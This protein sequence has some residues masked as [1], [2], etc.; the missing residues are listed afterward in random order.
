MVPI[1]TSGNYLIG[2]K[3]IRQ[4]EDLQLIGDKGADGGEEG[5]T[6]GTSGGKE[7]R[8]R[9]RRQLVWKTARSDGAREVNQAAR[10]PVQRQMFMFGRLLRAE[11]S[12]Q[13]GNVGVREARGE[14][15]DRRAGG[16]S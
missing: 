10:L 3:V 14:R 13:S 5:S 9:R 12:S 6:G 16:R 2:S 4:E 15:T 11:E 8:R 7:T 1:D